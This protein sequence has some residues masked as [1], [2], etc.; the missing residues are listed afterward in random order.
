MANLQYAGLIGCGDF[1]RW[2]IDD[3]NNSK[4]IKVKYTYDLNPEKS[5]LRAGQ[6]NAS[7]A[8]SAE[9]IFN[10]PE[11][12]TVYIFTPPFAR[13]EL[14]KMAVDHGKNIITTKPFAV[15]YDAAKKLYNMVKDKVECGVF[16]GRAGNA[17]VEALK[18]IFD[19]GEIGNL[20]IYKEDWFH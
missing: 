12:S 5:G 14:F 15:N 8:E 3:L 2:L 9:Q 1:L 19:G 20:A 18:T 13:E 4:K 6:L 17:A 7:V 11:I 10:D 16:Y